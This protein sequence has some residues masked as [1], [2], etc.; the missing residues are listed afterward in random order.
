MPYSEEQTARIKELEAEVARLKALPEEARQVEQVN[1]LKHVFVA[2]ASHQLRTP[3]SSIK[4]ILS[5]LQDDAEM[6]AMP[7][8]MKLVD[9]A[10]QGMERAIDTV[11]DLINMT[12]IEDGKLPVTLQESELPAIITKA[13]NWSQ[14]VA[15]SRDLKIVSKVADTIPTFAFDPQL[16]TEVI[17]NLINNALDYSTAPSEIDIRAWNDDAAQ[18][19]IVTVS[20][21]GIGIADEDSE[22]VFM[23]FF[24]AE[25]ARNVHPDGSGLGLYLSKYIAIEHKGSLTYE[26]SPEGV[27]TFTLKLPIVHE[28]PAPATDDVEIPVVPTPV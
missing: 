7:T 2:T 24:R 12:R 28:A 8:K 4:W 23:P 25:A 26:K 11:N 22:N 27:I 10:F 1:E 6:K 13:L 21:T 17:E 18:Q 20:N 3:L 5:M 9:Q 14:K 19:V 15:E 16:I